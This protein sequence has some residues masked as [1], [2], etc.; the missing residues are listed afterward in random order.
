MLELNIFIILS[1]S[2][3]LTL[4]LGRFL[5]KLKVPWVFAALIIGMLF[6][7]STKIKNII[8]N[9]SFELFG[10]LGMYF[11]LFIVGFELDLNKLIEK[12]KYVVQTAFF[13]ILFEAFFGA[14]LIHYLFDCDWLISSIVALSF[15]TVGEAVVVP[16][17]DE[18]GII[19]T[20]FGQLLIGIGTIDDI[21]E[22]FALT[23]VVVLIGSETYKSTTIFS[24]IAVLLIL[25][26]LCYGLTRLGK[27]SKKFKFKKIELLILLSL[28]ILFIFVGVGKLIDADALA[29]LLAG[30]SIRTFVPK[31]RLKKIEKEIKTI[32]Y[33]LF[34]PIFF[35]WAG[36]TTQ[37]YY[38]INN[39]LIVI[40]ITSFCCFLKIIASLLSTSKILG[41]RKSILLGLGLSIRFST[42]IVILKILLENKLI[43]IDLYSIL[44]ATTVVF[45]LIIPTIL[46]RELEKIYKSKNA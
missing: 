13:I 32:C 30:I 10:Q 12:T 21:I 8:L 23:C 16:I 42:S 15:A 41:I 39:P 36:A 9:P 2:F 27:E 26:V 28:S 7:L 3:L 29:A 6:S 19:N 43:G 38:I 1:L 11:L 45:K 24:I 20:D 35:L 40:G 44:M 14:L 37:A 33:G 25:F 34:A 22:V 46:S 17:L 5:E 4:I 18:L 31:E